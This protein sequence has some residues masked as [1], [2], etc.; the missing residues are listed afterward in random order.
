MRCERLSDSLFSVMTPIY[1]HF[2]ALEFTIKEINEDPQILPNLTLGFHIYNS[3][4]SASWTYHA[5]LELFSAQDELIPNYNCDIQNR[6]I[7]VIG[8]PTFEV[9]LH[10]ATI[11]SLY[12]V[13]QVQCLY[14]Q[15]NHSLSF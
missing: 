11:L 14:L 13:P 9:C 3:Y 1:Q 5:S 12:K 15:I 8:G 7:A 10:V 2:L 4:F 6:I